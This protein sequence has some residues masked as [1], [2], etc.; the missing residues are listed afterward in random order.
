MPD[1]GMTTAPISVAYSNLK[2]L[3]T[4]ARAVVKWSKQ[5]KKQYTKTLISK[6]I[7]VKIITF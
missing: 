1:T 5:A 4:L 3:V 6:N 7:I 2:R